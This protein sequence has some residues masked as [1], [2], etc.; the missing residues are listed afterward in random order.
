MESTLDQKYVRQR[1]IIPEE[2]L[3]EEI[4]IVGAG[5]VG[6]CC[7]LALAKTGFKNLKVFDFDT[8]EIHNMPNQMYRVRDLGKPKVQALKE[9]IHDFEGL[10]IVTVNGKY[11]ALN[12]RGT[13]IVAVDNMDARIMFWKK[14]QQHLKNIN[15]Y[16]DSRMGAELIRLYSFQPMY[17][18]DIEIYEQSLYTSEDA[19]HL[20][21]TAKATMYT[22]LMLGSMIVSQAKRAYM[23]MI[24]GDYLKPEVE[25]IL[26]I[27]SN[28]MITR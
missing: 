22:A 17:P 27:P 6:S 12:M 20:S 24:S 15:L 14:A 11:R 9:I 8:V 1:D 21:C 4:T 10:D 26:D 16:I 23:S 19:E 7:A 3:T 28:T 13:I 18:V 25:I 5:A 2:I